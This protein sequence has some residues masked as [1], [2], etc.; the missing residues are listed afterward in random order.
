MNR[1]KTTI[2][3]LIL[4]LL[5]CCQNTITP[6]TNSLVTHG[7]IS[8]EQLTLIHEYLNTF[9]DRTQVSFAFIE[10][11][12]VFF[13]G[14]IRNND[15]L[16][17]RTDSMAVYEIGSITKVFTSTLLSSFVVE[18]TLALDEKINDHL[19]VELKDNAEISFMELANHTS[20]LPRLP[21]NFALSSLLNPKNPYKNYDE[22]KLVNYLTREMELNDEKKSSYSNLGAGLLAYVLEKYSG[23]DYETLLKER[24]FRKYGMKQSTSKRENIQELLV[25]GLDDAGNNTPNWDL[26]SLVGAGGILSNTVDLSRFA[27]AQFDTADQALALT[28]VVTY[29][30]PKGMDVALGWHIV[31]SE[32][33]IFYWHNGGTG[34]YTSSMILDLEN[35]NGVIILSNISAF[36]EKSR[37]I[38][39]LSTELLK[40]MD[41]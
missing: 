28:R 4:P 10:D 38:D 40:G 15:T 2:L 17:T 12:T 6:A 31:K 36:H 39:R 26:A 13:Y 8:Q 23:K 14:V 41:E 18:G 37:Q 11:S 34:G 19:K 9:P 1:L 33:G 21:S 16:F 7:G 32:K 24:I 20:G 22:E 25:P 27:L 29:E 3:L 5:T 35:R 30:N